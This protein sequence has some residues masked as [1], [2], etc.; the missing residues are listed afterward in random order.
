VNTQ[1]TIDE[2][3]RLVLPKPLLE[4]LHLEPGDVLE[5]ESTGAQITLRPVRETG[6]LFQEHGIWVYST[7]QPISAE[8]TDEL[9]QQIR[10]ERDLT[11]LNPGE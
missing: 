5:L 6:S 7:G 1:L 3:G 4:E 10:R 9:L 2:A 11:N 8:T